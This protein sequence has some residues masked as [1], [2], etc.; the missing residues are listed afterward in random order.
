[1]LV[2]AA[3]RGGNVLASLEVLES[4]LAAWRDCEHNAG[5]RCAVCG[6]GIAGVVLNCAR[7]AALDCPLRSK[8]FPEGKW[9]KSEKNKLVNP[10]TIP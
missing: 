9:G 8:D 10:L 4:R 7:Y 2:R 1:M 6:C 3:V 5:G